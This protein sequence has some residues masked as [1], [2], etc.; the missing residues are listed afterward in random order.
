MRVKGADEEIRVEQN[1]VD[2]CVFMLVGTETGRVRGLLLT[3]VDDLLLLTDPTLREPVQNKLKELFPV[4]DWED[5]TFSYVGC[6]YECSPEAVVIKQRNYCET[7]VD[8]VSQAQRKQNAPTVRDL[9]ETNKMVDAARAGAER[10]LTLHRVAEQDLVL[11]AFHDA[12][13]ANVHHPE[14][15]TADLEWNGEHTL[16]SQLASVVVVCDRKTLEGGAGKFG[17]VEW[18]SKASQRVCRSTF[19]GETMACSDALESALF[20]RG[21]LVSMQLGH[22]VPERDCGEHLEVHLVTDCKS[23]YD[24]VHREGTPKAPT[25]K[26]LALDLASIRQV[27]LAMQG[28]DMELKELRERNQ[29]LKRALDDSAQLLNDVMQ[30]ILREEVR[31]MVFPLRLP[32]VLKDVKSYLVAIFQDNGRVN[33]DLVEASSLNLL[34]QGMRQLQQMYLEKGNAQ[35]GDALKGSVELPQLP[36]LIGETGV[37]FSDWLYVAEQT[38]GWLSDSATTWFSMTLQCAKEAYQQHQVATPLD[39]L[40]IAPKIPKDLTESKWSRLERKVMTM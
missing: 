27:Q 32:P 3:H 11:V 16:S 4:D 5:D 39:R 17:I 8:K 26:R 38:I 10:G 21:L 14:V 31:I 13:W 37:E 6:E 9:K 15:S 20:L 1:T 12:A 2:P 29:E 33:L 25:E 18:K 30:V 22:A 24:H 35:G 23:L 34:V 19:A 7:R 36:E 40:S 28:R